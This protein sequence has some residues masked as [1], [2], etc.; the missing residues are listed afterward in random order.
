MTKRTTEKSK[1]ATA[2]A[3]P[4]MQRSRAKTG[5]PGSA[6]SKAR[7]TKKDVRSNQDKDGNSE[8]LAR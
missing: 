8:Q 6:S 7:Q 3:H 5:A 1:T 2:G 4:E